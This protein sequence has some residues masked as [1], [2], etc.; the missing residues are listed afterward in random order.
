MKNRIITVIPFAFPKKRR[1]GRWDVKIPTKACASI[2]LVFSLNGVFTVGPQ[3][4]MCIFKKDMQQSFKYSHIFLFKYF[5]CF[6]CCFY[7]ENHYFGHFEWAKF[8]RWSLVGIRQRHQKHFRSDRITAAEKT[9]L[10]R[11]QQTQTEDKPD[12]FI[13]S[14][15]LFSS[16]LGNPRWVLHFEMSFHSTAQM[17]LP[18]W[19]IS[20]HIW[21]WHFVK[22]TSFTACFFYIL[23]PRLQFLFPTLVSDSKSYSNGRLCAPLCEQI[24]L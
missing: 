16:L 15:D 6:F 2:S 7:L 1:L 8:N 13:F 18:P 11:P 20:S 19:C 23:M 24:S 14:V 22:Q 10:I 17:H 12:F 9:L 3:G 4:G 21:P 5:P